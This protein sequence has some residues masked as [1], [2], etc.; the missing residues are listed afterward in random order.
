VVGND[1]PKDV[2][3]MLQF[4][5]LSKAV[6]KWME[7]PEKFNNYREFGTDLPKLSKM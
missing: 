5:H 2:S 1:D 6:P 7:K 3:L 4:T